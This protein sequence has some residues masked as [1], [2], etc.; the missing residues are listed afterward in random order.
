MDIADL[1]G[2]GPGHNWLKHAARNVYPV[3]QW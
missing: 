2:I 1:Y 3:R